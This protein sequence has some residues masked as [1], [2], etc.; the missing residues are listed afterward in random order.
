M[1]FVTDPNSDFVKVLTVTNESERMVRLVLKGNYSLTLEVFY[2]QLGRYEWH[3]E[4]VHVGREELEAMV[5][6]LRAL[7]VEPEAP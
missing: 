2:C 3:A 6:A 7:P 4:Q 1:N 5:D